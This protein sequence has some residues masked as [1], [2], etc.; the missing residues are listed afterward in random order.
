MMEMAVQH[1]DAVNNSAKHKSEELVT[2]VSC[3][4]SHRPQEL[5]LTQLKH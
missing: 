4:M 1:R 2:A 3:A 5:W